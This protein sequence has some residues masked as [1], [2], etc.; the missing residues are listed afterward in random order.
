MISLVL[1]DLNLLKP[2]NRLLQNPIKS[3]SKLSC[4]LGDITDRIDKLQVGQRTTTKMNKTLWREVAVTMANELYKSEDKLIACHRKEADNDFL[5]A[6]IG[7]LK[8][9]VQVRIFYW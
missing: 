1:Q 6:F 8:D 7:E 3:C 2:L 9:K 5:T 4:Q